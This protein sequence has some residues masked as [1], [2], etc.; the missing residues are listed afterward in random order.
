MKKNFFILWV[1]FSLFLIYYGVQESFAQGQEFLRVRSG[2]L[3]SEKEATPGEFPMVE[4][5]IAPE[6]TMEIFIWQNP[7]LSKHIVVGPDGFISYPLVGRIK[8]AG[9]SVGQLEDT[10][11][12]KISEYVKNPQVSVMMTKFAGNQVIVLGEV[13]Y[14]GIYS[15]KGRATLIDAIALAGDFTVKSR[16]DCVLLVRGNL[17]DKPQVTRINMLQVLTKGTTRQD[18]ILQPNDLIFVPKAFI[19]DFN[20]FLDNMM[21]TINAAMSAIDMRRAVRDLGGRLDKSS[22][23]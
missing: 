16:R 6:D 2:T 1:I 9:L 13:G 21:P 15:Y 18:I 5:F 17:T 4:Y 12:E 8:V 20:Q 22:Q 14:A 19:A 3:A 23:Y 11:R 10:F 7:D